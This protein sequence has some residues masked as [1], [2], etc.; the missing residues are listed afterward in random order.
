M[1]ALRCLLYRTEL[2][3]TYVNLDYDLLLEQISSYNVLKTA[4]IKCS[5]RNSR[6]AKMID[7]KI[8]LALVTEMLVKSRIEQIDPTFQVRGAGKQLIQRNDLFR[9]VKD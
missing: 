3:N 4:C 5:I 6:G 7:L 8:M 2:P 9:K 1:H